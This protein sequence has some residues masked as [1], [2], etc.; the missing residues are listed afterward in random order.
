MTRITHISD[1]YKYI[2]SL[3]V[4][5]VVAQSCCFLLRALFRQHLASFAIATAVRFFGAQRVSGGI[6]PTAEH[7]PSKAAVK[8]AEIEANQ[9]VAAFSQALDSAFEASARGAVG[10]QQ[11]RSA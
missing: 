1:T 9:M 8:T 10:H 5:A 7:T 4:S 3:Q 2:V 11:R 6:F